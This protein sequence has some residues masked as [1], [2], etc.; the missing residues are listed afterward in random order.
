MGKS[1][2]FLG[3]ESTLDWL[4]F[5]VNTKN[6]SIPEIDEDFHTALE[7]LVPYL[8]KSENLVGKKINGHYVTC[9][10]LAELFRVLC[11]L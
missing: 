8:F 5:V 4:M 2:P 11:L 10:E 1:V 7:G 6:D 9:G 3:V